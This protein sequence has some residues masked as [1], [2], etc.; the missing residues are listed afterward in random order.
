MGTQ[1]KREEIPP[2]SLKRRLFRDTA[3]QP[4]PI[5]NGCQSHAARPDDVLFDHLVGADEQCLRQ[6]H[7][8]FLRR[9]RIDR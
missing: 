7:S 9:F 4:H 8:N 5:G 6:I 1:P 3:Q 2:I